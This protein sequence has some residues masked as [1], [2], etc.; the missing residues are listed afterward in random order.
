MNGEPRPEGLI[1]CGGRSRRLGTDKALV[2]V[3]GVALVERVRAALA[4]EAGRLR[5]VAAEPGRLSEM[6]LD[7][8]VDPVP[9]AGP[10][11]A[12]ANALAQV[13]TEHA[14]VVSCDMPF[15]EPRFFRLLREMIGPADVCLPWSEKARM[16]LAA[17]YRRGV[18]E[19][20]RAYRARGGVRLLPFV[21]ELLRCGLGEDALADLPDELLMNVN[22]EGDRERAET[23]AARRP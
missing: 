14:F 1:L 4:P 5:L 3:G 10:T 15:L 9:Y 12:L 20:A 6:G 8:I 21:S 17:L 7:V 22:S 16:P 19:K 23:L 2:T 18:A 13:E 11:A